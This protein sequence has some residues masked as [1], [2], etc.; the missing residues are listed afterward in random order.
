MEQFA[1]ELVLSPLS[2]RMAYDSKIKFP[3]IKKGQRKLLITEIRVLT[4]WWNRRTTPSLLVVYAGAAP[5]THI[6]VLIAMFPDI[7]FHLY[8]PREFTIKASEKVVLFTGKEGWVTDEV[9]KKYSGRNDVLFI[10]DIRNT[11]YTSVM[12]I[13]NEKLVAVD[14]EMQRKWVDIMRPLIAMLK[15]RLPYIIPGNPLTSEYLQGTI[16]LQPYSKS[17]SSE[18]RL[19]VTNPASTFTYDNRMFEDM[20]F[21]HNTKRVRNPRWNEQAEQHIL[22]EYL[23]RHSQDNEENY[24]ALER[25]ISSVVG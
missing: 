24:R 7:T 23:Q 8:D 11:D 1:Q 13:K 6:K 16:C 12:D 22:R 3:E 17:S 25:F 9:V 5:G 14:M 10:S 18:C 15:F 2:P 4:L 20:I 19:V 21:A